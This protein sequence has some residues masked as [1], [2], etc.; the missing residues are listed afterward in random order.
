MTYRFLSIHIPMSKLLNTSFITFTLLSQN[1]DIAMSFF[2]M[3]GHIYLP[4]KVESFHI[5][6]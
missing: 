6:R 2:N 1:K 5:V 4:M 3:K